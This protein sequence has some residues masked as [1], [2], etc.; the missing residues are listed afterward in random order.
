MV[1]WSTSGKAASQKIQ[2]G[3]PPKILVSEK[4]AH[5]R[6]SHAW[7]VGR[8]RAGALDV[9]M[10]RRRDAIRY[11]SPARAGTIRKPPPGRSGDGFSLARDPRNKPLPPHPNAIDATI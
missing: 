5:Q 11:R 10:T 1:P 7:L 9:M 2:T 4:F 3:T 8:L 6:L